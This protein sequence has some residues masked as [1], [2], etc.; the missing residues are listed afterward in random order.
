MKPIVS[1]RENLVF[2]DVHRGCEN[3]NVTGW[4]RAFF[5]APQSLCRNSE[6]LWVAAF[7]R[8]IRGAES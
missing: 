2:R 6:S 5:V 3:R 1:E 7:I 8:D 4:Q